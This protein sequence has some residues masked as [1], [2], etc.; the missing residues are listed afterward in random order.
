MGIERY[1]PKGDTILA[2]PSLYTILVEFY[3][4]ESLIFA[5]FGFWA[6]F[7]PRLWSVD[8][9][10]I[11]VEGRSE[12]FKRLIIVL[13]EWSAIETGVPAPLMVAVLPE[14]ILPLVILGQNRVFFYHS[15]VRHSSNIAFH[16][17]DCWQ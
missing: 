12:G 13:G 7:E 2:V 10:K 6:F 14:S 3:T 15:P 17:R 8:T 11:V 4:G 5:Y 16:Q 9:T 1:L